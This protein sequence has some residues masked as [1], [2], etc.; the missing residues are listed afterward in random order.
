MKVLVACEYSGVVRDAFRARGHDAIS[1]DLRPTLQGGPH[2]QG[3]VRAVLQH[4]WD[5]VIAH[6]PCTYMTVASNRALNEDPTR[7]QSLEKAARF[8]RECLEANAERVCVENPP[9]LAPARAIIG[10]EPND[11]AHAH[12]FGHHERKLYRL[13]TRG[14]PP[15]M[16]TCIVV[17][18]KTSQLAR[19]KS[20]RRDVF[21]TGIARAMADQWGIL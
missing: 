21:H 1:C 14:L 7:M 4:P 8:L 12:H 2:A 16:P 9:M 11:K 13:W 3:D 17:N 20:K 10:R 6:P 19:W 5:L 18:P 15:L